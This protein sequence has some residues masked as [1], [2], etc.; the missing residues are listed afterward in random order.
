[1]SRGLVSTR[2]MTV[3]QRQRARIASLAISVLAT[4]AVVA[5]GSSGEGVTPTWP[6]T[7]G[8]VA[9]DAPSDAASERPSVTSVPPTGGPAASHTWGPLAVVPP[10]SGMDMS[11]TEGTVRITDSCVFLESGADLTLL[12]W[13]ED[14]TAWDAETRTI[15]FANVDGGRVTLGDGMRVAIGGSGESIEESGLTVEAWLGRTPWVSRPAA[16]CPLDSYWAVGDVSRL[17]S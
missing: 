6:S 8:P 14:R 3:S 1:M 13:P 4:I 5:C 7:P 17:T 2:R 9:S 11:R 16:S 12:V 15:A 10:Q